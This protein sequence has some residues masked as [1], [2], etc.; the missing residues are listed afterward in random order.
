M[1]FSRKNRIAVSIIPAIMITG[2]SYLFWP[3]EDDEKYNIRWDQDKLAYKESFLNQIR[4]DEG[5]DRPNI[6][7]IMAD[8]LGKSEVSIYGNSNVPTPHIDSIA[9]E[10]VNF[11]EGYITSP[12]CSPSRAGLI[13]GRYQQRFGYEVQPHDRY[14]RNMLEFLGFK[15][16]VDTDG[17]NLPDLDEISYPDQVNI[18]RQGLPPSEIT[19]GE[20]FQAYGY[21]TAMIGK[22]HLGYGEHAQPHKRGFDYTFGF[23]EA[24]SWYVND[25]GNDEVIGHHHDLFI[26]PYIWGKERTGTAAITRNGQVIEDEGYLTDRI[27]EESVSFIEEYKDQPFLLYVPFNAPHTPFQVTRKYYDRFPGIAD[28]NKRVYYAMISALD[29]AV[30]MITQKIKEE[31]LEENTLIFFLSDNGGATYTQATTN[32][33][34]KGGKMSDFEGGLNIPLMMK[35][36][37][38]IEGGTVYSKPISSLDIFSTACAAAGIITPKDRLYDGV[39]LIPFVNGQVG[40]EPHKAIFWRA[41]YNKIMRKG[42]WKLI[43]NDLSGYQLLYNLESDK[44]E[45][46]NLSS[47]YPEIVS[48]L[49]ADF[50]NWSSTLAQPLWPRIMDYEYTIDGEVYTFSN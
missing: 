24:Y 35:W 38:H 27:A 33:P 21:K 32:H 30:G 41:E 29:D 9:L 47:Q 37:G 46:K 11:T 10:G 7:I 44:I 4:V 12:I 15:Y 26:D 5:V 18:D 28:H 13:T 31:K 22:W 17:W 50:N 1:K 20:L 19:I 49:K 14:P 48:E 23:Y 16:F 40:D 3:L 42:K 34:L 39:D 45:S 6:I 2:G 8:D 25:M 36:Q 43:M